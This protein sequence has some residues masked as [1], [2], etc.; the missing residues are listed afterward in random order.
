LFEY[1]SSYQG[2]IYDQNNHARYTNNQN[3]NERKKNEKSSLRRV[4]KIAFVVS[5]V[6]ILSYIPHVAISLLTAVKGSFLLEPG[7]QQCHEYDFT[8]LPKS[9]VHESVNDRVCNIIYHY[10][11]C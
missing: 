3:N 1:F 5:V 11:S 9:F 2:I 4:T 7:P 8:I 10:R 6:F